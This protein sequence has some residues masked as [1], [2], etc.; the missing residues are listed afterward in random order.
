[1]R[2][3]ECELVGGNERIGLGL[4]YLLEVSR[5]RLRLRLRLRDMIC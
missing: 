3:V 5:L 2:E 1:M 4:D